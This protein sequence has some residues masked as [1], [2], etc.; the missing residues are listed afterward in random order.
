MLPRNGSSLNGELIS[1]SLARGTE[2]KAQGENLQADIQIQLRERERE[3]GGEDER[4][5]IGTG[6]QSPPLFTAACCCEISTTCSGG[7]SS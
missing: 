6:T 3:G 4:L 7:I 5:V 1:N 2:P